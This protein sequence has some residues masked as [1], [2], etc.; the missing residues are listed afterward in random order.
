M[1]QP[2]TTI[3]RQEA[4]QHYLQGEQGQ[5]IVRISP[6]WTWILVLILA[7]AIMSALL[8]SF[9]GSVDINGRGRGI[10]RPAGGIRTLTSQTSGTVR[11]IEVMSGRTVKAGTALIKINAPELQSEILLAER[12]IDAVKNEFKKIAS[13]QEKFFTEQSQR[14]ASRISLLEE[15]LKSHTQSVGI[16]ERRLAA[17]E[18]LA[19]D[20][21]VSSMEVDAAREELAQARRQ[22]GATMQAL[23]Q[24]IQE[25]AALDSRRQ[26]ELWQ[27][28][29]L[30][31]N[32]VVKR[33]ALSIVQ[34]QTEIAAPEDGIV[35]ALLVKPG[36]VIQAGQ[37]VGKLIPQGSPLHV[38]S[39]LFEKDRAFVKTGDE[40]HLELD[41]LPYSEFGTLRAKII[42]I[43][44]D[45]ASP[46]EIEEALG[47]NQ[48][49]EVP[50]FR[51]EL[52]V[53]DDKAL[54]KAQKALRSGM[55]MN[56]RYTLRKQRLITIVID[57]LRRWFR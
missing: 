3:Y 26:D 33:D 21:V 8:G 56:V 43:S 1:T 10:V 51:V 37:A 50:T 6:V 11:S 24:T 39:F 27:G 46:Y 18:A 47:P 57:P 9:I 32:A 25:K 38:V 4:L 34:N 36:E 20:S 23:D 16:Y 17:R 2:N 54:K 40:V 35:E 29:Q 42:R 44:D 55:M 30:W 19:K 22:A 52:Q 14:I 15:Q 53:T 31:R 45:L 5:G 7:A 13:Q 48:R 49:F 28:D 41:Q 12:Q